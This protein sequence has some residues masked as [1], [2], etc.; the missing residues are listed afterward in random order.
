ML[1]P[2]TA[3]NTA[4]SAPAEHCRSPYRLVVITPKIAVL[5]PCVSKDG[6]GER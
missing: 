5:S 2:K 6:I 1:K 4:A 3:F